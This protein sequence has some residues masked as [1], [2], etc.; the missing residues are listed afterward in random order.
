MTQTH[1]KFKIFYGEP[2][3]DGSPGELTNQIEQ[4]VNDHRVSPK[5]IGAEFLE[6]SGRIIITLGYR[7]DEDPV[8]VRI[9]AARLGS[10]GANAG[11]ADVARL[12]A[13]ITQAAASAHHILCH[14]LYVTDQDELF[15]IFMS[16]KI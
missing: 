8:P 9:H 10:I 6:R 14:E 16:Q 5:S 4:F 1:H 11:P 2:A 7:D 13:A 3:A 15:M 12:E